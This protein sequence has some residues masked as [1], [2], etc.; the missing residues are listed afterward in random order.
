MIKDLGEFFD[1]ED[2]QRREDFEKNKTAIMAEEAR[3]HNTP[4]AI[5]RQEEFN[6]LLEQADESEDEEDEEDEE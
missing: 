2:R 4:E 3:K 6:R 5:A 1:E